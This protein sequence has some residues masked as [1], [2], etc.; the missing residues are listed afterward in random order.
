MVEIALW[1]W[2]TCKTIVSK[3][4]EMLHLQMQIKSLPCQRQV[5]NQQPPKTL[6]TSFLVHESPFQIDL[7]IMDVVPFGNLKPVCSLKYRH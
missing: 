2:N 1:T 3:H 5:I 6:L 7:D 4:S